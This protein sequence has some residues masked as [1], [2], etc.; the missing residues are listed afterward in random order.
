MNGTRERG[1]KR[2]SFWAISFAWDKARVVI[3]SSSAARRHFTFRPLVFVVSFF[4]PFE[5][6]FSPYPRHFSFLYYKPIPNL[7]FLFLIYWLTLTQMEVSKL[8]TLGI[9]H[10]RAKTMVS[11]KRYNTLHNAITPITSPGQ[12]QSTTT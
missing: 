5:I 2:S 9:S 11:L 4:W 3:T 6:Y 10:N 7:I 12:K 1:L 8:Q